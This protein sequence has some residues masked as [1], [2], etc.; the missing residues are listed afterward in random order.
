MGYRDHDRRLV[1]GIEW[2]LE[3][4]HSAGPKVLGNLHVDNVLTRDS[5]TFKNHED[6]GDCLPGTLANGT[7]EL[8]PAFPLGAKLASAPR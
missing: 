8:L 3:L 7:L 1:K 4:R 2:C 6:I 5:L